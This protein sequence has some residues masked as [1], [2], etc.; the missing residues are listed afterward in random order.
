MQQRVNGA[1]T[2]EALIILPLVIWI[3]LAGL[4]LLWIFWAQHTLHNTGHYV[5]RAGQV[6]GGSIT[7][8]TNVLATGMAATAPQ[9]FATDSDDSHQRQA[10]LQATTKMLLHAR[11]AAQITR[12]S[13]TQTQAQQFAE[14]RFSLPQQ[15][16]V[17]EIAVDHAL[18]RTAILTADEQQQW[19]AARQLDIEIWWCLPLQVPM[20]APALQSWRQWVDDAAQRFCRSRELVLGQPLWPLVTRRKGPMLSGF[21]VDD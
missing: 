2:I 16:W 14:R 1:S 21:R 19:L 10:A 18:G 8:M 12:H 4:Q 7:N 13:P 5:L 20:V 15:Q 11:V 17:Q 9:W 3:A 6:A